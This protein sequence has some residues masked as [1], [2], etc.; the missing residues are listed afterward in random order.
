[1]IQ[2]DATKRVVN[3]INQQKQRRVVISDVISFLKTFVSISFSR[4]TFFRK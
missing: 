1:M 3:K 2:L 4:K